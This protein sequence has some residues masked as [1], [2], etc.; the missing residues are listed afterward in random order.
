MTAGQRSDGSWVAIDSQRSWEPTATSC[1]ALRRARDLGLAVEEGTETRAAMF[2][3][4]AFLSAG[5]ADNDPKAVILHALSLTGSA[6]FAHVNRLY[7]ER[8]TLSN[9]ALAYTALTLANMGRTDMAGELLDVLAGRAKEVLGRVPMVYW[10]GSAHH[11]WLGDDMEA[12]AMASLAFSRIRPDTTLV[13]PSVD[14]L[15]DRRGAG[16]V[17]PAKARGPV[18]AAVA[19][20]FQRARQAGQDYRL[21]IAVNDHD[22]RTLQVVGPGE[23]LAIPVPDAHLRSGENIVRFA[24]QGRDE[25]A[26]G[27]TLSGFSVVMTDPGTIRPGVG[28]RQYFHDTLR[29]KGRSIGAPST[30]LVEKIEVGQ[31][32]RVQVNFFNHYYVDYLVVE[33]P[34]PAG[35]V[36]VP[37]SIQSSAAHVRIEADRLLFYYEPRRLDGRIGYEVIGHAGGSYRVP[38][39]VIRDVMDPVKMRIGSVAEL[40]VLDPGAASDDPYKMNRPE[41]FALG[42]LHFEDGEY[43]GA[44]RY[45]GHLFREQP[46]YQERDLARMLLWIHTADGFYDARRIVQVFEILRERYPQLEIPFD[47][48][49]IVGRAYHD[50]DEFERAALVYRATID[51]S[52]LND[53]HLSA[54]LEDEGQ[55]LGSIDYMRA[56]WREYP[57]TAEVSTA[58]FGLSQALYRK[59]PTAHELAKTPQRPIQLPG[60]ARAALEIPP[61]RIDLLEEAIRLLESFMTL[62][63]ANPLADDA[64]FSMANAYLDLTLYEKVIELSQRYR[65][66]YGDSEYASGFEYMRALGHFWRLEYEPAL[67]A[68]KQVAGG[69]S[70]DRDF[71]T[72]IVGQIYH[73][74]EK[75]AEAIEW[76][77]RVR[78]HYADAAESIRYFERQH[79]GLD[80]VALFQPGEAVEVTLRY[81]NIAEAAVQVYRVDLMKLY[82]REKSLAKMADVNL[83]GIQPEY[84][85]TFAL[86]DGLDYVDKTRTLN[87]DLDDEGAYLLIVRGDDLFASGMVL[88][89]PLAIDVQ[90]DAVSGRV[91]VYLRD[92]ILRRPVANVHVKAIGSEGGRFRE[93]DTDLRGLFIADAIRGRATVIARDDHA[94]YAFYRGEQWLGAAPEDRAPP[95]PEPAEPAKLDYQRSLREGQQSIQMLNYEAYDQMRRNV[96]RGVQIQQAR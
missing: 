42:R 15:L 93:G 83:A 12:T 73:A 64:A 72:Y 79:I 3:Q 92:E 61:T 51:V 5:A 19:G 62:Y 2:L 58:Y 49:L 20:Y 43:A 84:S 89:T 18:V 7:R 41:Y 94:R 63:P 85:E 28:S 90:E 59:A 82:L 36:L 95:T 57:D 23:T 9:P 29:Y 22:L 74:Q 1:W 52:F 40:T 10:E 75:P 56:L 13:R 11:P 48:I 96:Q 45:L 24:M 81:R 88:V 38:P 39:T 80:E 33:E 68:A 53:A 30:S 50:L 4:R 91:R 44:L 27:V 54:L 55:F 76:Y 25:Y 70:R 14:W 77:R 37:G 67:A 71:A 65:Q 78:E 16:A 6:E 69:D 86:G 46:D 8:N 87:L 47:R 60:H 21:A 17:R 26:Y 34:L 31:R 32:V 35:M 66:W